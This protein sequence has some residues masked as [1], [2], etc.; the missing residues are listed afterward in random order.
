VFY[1]K[2]IA[3]NTCNMKIN[4]GTRIYFHNGSSMEVRKGASLN[5][6][7][8]LKSPVIFTSDRLDDDY[9]AIPGLWQ[10]IWLENGSKNISFTYAEITN[11][12]I[13]LL[14]D[15]CGLADNEPLR[16][17][18]CMIN[19]MSD[20]GIRATKAKIVATNCQITNCGGNVVSIEQGGNYDFR[21]CTLA[22]YFATRSY[23]ALSISNYS[24]DTNGKQIPGDLT[25]AYFG[26]CIVTG[27]QQEEIAFYE[28]AGTPFVFKFDQCLVTWRKEN[29]PGK[30]YESKFV[31]C[32]VNKDAKFKD[33]GNNNFQLDTLSFAKDAASISIINVTVPD[34]SLDRKGISRLIPGPPDLGVYERVERK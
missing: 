4:A 28:K 10:G 13:G 2:F 25:G 16:L 11:A 7:G 34:I 9:L 22:R 27:N 32:V 20:F 3:G 5:V 17:H 24:T 18:N 31:N 15:S 1:G 23:P 8:T 19:N 21:G 6:T 26:N 14:A 30:G 29:Y 33:P 12:V